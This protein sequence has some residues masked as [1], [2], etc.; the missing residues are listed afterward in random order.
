MIQLLNRLFRWSTGLTYLLNRLFTLLGVR[1]L[2]N[3]LFTR[4]Q[5]PSH[6]ARV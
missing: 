5:A 1:V 3:R 2:L 6:V 4:Y